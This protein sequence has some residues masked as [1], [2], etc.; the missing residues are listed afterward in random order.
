MSELIIFRVWDKKEWHMYY[1]PAAELYENFFLRADGLL[2]DVDFSDCADPEP[3]NDRYEVTLFTGL[4]DCDGK[5]IYKD[6]IIEIDMYG[7]YV[8]E[9][10][11]G[12]FTVECL[13][14]RCLEGFMF[15]PHLLI[16]GVNGDNVNPHAKII[17][18][19]FEHPELLEMK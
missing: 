12:A 17:G 7:R 8:V 10:C 16:D 3:V 11:N 15:D 4:Y 13:E 2:C 14:K 18:N 6:D 19:R 9:F 1:F 5:K